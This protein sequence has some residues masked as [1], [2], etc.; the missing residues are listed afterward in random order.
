M[1]QF[2]TI[3]DVGNLESSRGEALIKLAKERTSRG[4]APPPEIFR[5]EYRR[6][7][8]WSEFPAW[9]QPVDPQV[10]DGCCHEG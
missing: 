9:A 2:N 3:C 7:V 5:I 1:I 10:F 8:D 6:R 4:L